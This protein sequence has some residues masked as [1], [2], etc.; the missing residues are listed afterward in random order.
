M[1][2]QRT[3]LSKT[4]VLASLQCEKM[5]HLQVHHPELAVFSS[6]TQSAFQQGHEVGRVARE[7]YARPGAVHLDDGPRGLQSVLREN[8]F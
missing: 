7:I 2:S 5:L 3:R 1:G 6:A 4:R 8:A